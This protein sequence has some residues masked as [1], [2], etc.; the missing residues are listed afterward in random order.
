MKKRRDSPCIDVCKFDG[1]TGWCAGCGRTLEEARQWRSMPP[2][3]RGIVE[4]S[5]ANRMQ[6]LRRDC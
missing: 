6:K 4:R 5:L 2:F 1:K 3:R